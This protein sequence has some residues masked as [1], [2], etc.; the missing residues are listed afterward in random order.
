MPTDTTDID[1]IQSTGEIVGPF[2]DMVQRTSNVV[3]ET[4]AANIPKDLHWEIIL[5][6]VAIASLIW[7]IRGGR[8]SKGV[9]GRERKTG[10]VEFLLPG[11]IY[12]HVSARVDIWLWLIERVFSTG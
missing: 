3:W 12:T 6:T 11:D 1:A 4:T 10:L 8:G 5:L 7:L 9:D 2:T